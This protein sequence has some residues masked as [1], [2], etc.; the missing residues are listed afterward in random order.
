MRPSGS[1][2]PLPMELAFVVQLHV[3][4]EVAWGRIIGH[5]EHVPSEQAAHFD[6]LEDLL[7]FIERVLTKASG[8]W[9]ASPAARLPLQVA[10]INSSATTRAHPQP[11]RPHRHG[12]PYRHRRE[13]WSERPGAQLRWLNGMV[14]LLMQTASCHVRSR[15]STGRLASLSRGWRS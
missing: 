6:T 2:R 12:I 3:E 4:T 13:P 15:G 7:T 11:R 14:F 9:R 1:N 5:V 8:T 10:A